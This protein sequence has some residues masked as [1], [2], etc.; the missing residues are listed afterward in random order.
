[1]K[2]SYFLEVDIWNKLVIN[3]KTIEIN[4]QQMQIIQLCHLTWRGN[5]EGTEGEED[6]HR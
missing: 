5:G 2:A 3:I 4:I 6:P 1:M